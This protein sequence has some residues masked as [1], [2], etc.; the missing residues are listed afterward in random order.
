MVALAS[1]GD[2]FGEVALDFFI[3]ESESCDIFEPFACFSRV[4]SI[5]GV[6]LTAAWVGVVGFGVAAGLAGSA[7]K[8]DM[9]IKPAMAVTRSFFM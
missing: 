1:D 6:G 3:F 2:D 9:E 4:V 5:A 8:A 7:A